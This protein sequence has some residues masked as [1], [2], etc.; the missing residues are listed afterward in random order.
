V[1][2]ALFWSAMSKVKPLTLE[3]EIA[4]SIQVCSPLSRK[5]HVVLRVSLLQEFNLKIA[6]AAEEVIFKRFPEKVEY[7]KCFNL[8]TDV[9]L[10]ILALQSLI[11]GMNTPSSDYSPENPAATADVT[12]HPPPHPSPLPSTEPPAK[13]RK[14]DTGETLNGETLP[15]TLPGSSGAVYPQLVHANEHIRSIQLRN[16]KEFEDMIS[17]CVSAIMRRPTPS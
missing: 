13:K 10:Q 12:V 14:R 17:L 7:I 3:P 9:M 4:S 15:A 1:T 6:S 2:K 5:T 8:L 11:D 16:R